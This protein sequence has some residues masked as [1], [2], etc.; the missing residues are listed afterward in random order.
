MVSENGELIYCYRYC[1]K[2]KW[3]DFML[4]HW[5]LMI[6]EEVLETEGPNFGRH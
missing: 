2:E 1:I 5:Q 3:V 4:S 6:E